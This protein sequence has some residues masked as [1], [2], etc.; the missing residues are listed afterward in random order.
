MRHR[1]FIAVAAVVVLMLVGAV[2]VY[3]Y[4]SAREDRIAKGVTIAGVDVGGMSADRARRVVQRRVVAPLERPVAVLYRGRRFTLSA[5][6]AGL[7][8]D[9]PGMV[10]E[11]LQA[12]RDGSIITRVARDITGGEENADVAPRVSYSQK[13]VDGLVDRVRRKVNRP[14]RDA[15]VSFPSLHKVKEKNGVRVEVAALRN[16]V[17]RALT[18][19]ERSVTATVQVIKPKVT[20]DQLAD[21][22]PTVLVLTR[23]AFQLSL[24]KRLQLVKSY[25]V[26]VGQVGLETPAGL[27]HIE[28]KAVNPAWHVPNSAWAGSLAGTVVP[29]GPENPIKARWL[30]IF[31]GAGIHGTDEVW[32]LG[33]A[34]SHGCV[35]MSIPDVEALYPQV[36][37]GAPIYI[38]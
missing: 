2:A 13:A 38:A 15:T 12:S 28:N 9:V 35:R 30:G 26:A 18:S 1:S 10:D 17:E 29:P 16:R 14:A 33:H 36:P 19:T 25:T 23:G 21:K 22:Y 31:A 27:Y 4:D 34:V 37:V 20:T 3:A 24:Y 11:A 6:D 5:E 7:H 32:S 8:A